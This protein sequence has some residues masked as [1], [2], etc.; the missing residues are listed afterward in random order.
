MRSEW[1]HGLFNIFMNHLDK[2]MNNAKTN[3]ADDAKLFIAGLTTKA[4]V[5]CED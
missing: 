3:G 1:A 5:E 4:R 2:G